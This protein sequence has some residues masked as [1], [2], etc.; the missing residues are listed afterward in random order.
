M[1]IRLAVPPDLNEEETK[2]VLDAALEAMTR[3]HE[4]L[5]ARG[6]VPTAARAIKAGA[7]RWRPEP[8]GDEHF[9]LASSQL[10]RGWGDCDDLGPWH[11]GSLRA[12]GKDPE[13]RAEVRKSG[14]KRWHVVVRRHDGTVEDPSVAAGMGIVGGDEYQG[15]L[16]N[17][18]WADRFALATHPL[19][20]G[21]AAR[22]DVPSA[23][24]PFM[25]SALARAPHP[26]AAVVGACHV[27]HVCFDDA[28]P[29]HIARLAAIQD[30]LCGCDVS[31]VGEALE[32]VGFGPLLA[33]VLP[34]ATSLAAP[35]LNKLLPGGGGGG[36]AA[37][38]GPASMPSGGFPPGTTMHY[39]GGP[40]IVRF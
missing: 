24:L 2:A 37:P 15:P 1:R 35:V 4:P 3:A 34:A 30:L 16:W 19:Q 5:V 23:Q 28:N 40:I 6:V 12:T 31:V 11:A 9:D 7:V 14:P 13:A 39:P 33:S 20:S 27:K 38:A 10:E 25:Y 26:A 18:M 21:W 17:P 22:I 32:Q 36:G 8:P 29:E